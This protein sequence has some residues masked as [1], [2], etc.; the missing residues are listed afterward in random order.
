MYKNGK[1]WKSNI[2][3]VCFP[4]NGKNSLNEVESVDNH[5]GSQN[6]LEKVGNPS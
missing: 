5:I 1:D 6:V 2:E 3:Y 4:P